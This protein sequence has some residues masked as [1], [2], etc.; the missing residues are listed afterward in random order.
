M[1][2]F[3]HVA[4]IYANLLETEESFYRTKEFNSYR[5]GLEHRH[6]RRF[7]TFHQIELNKKINKMPVLIFDGKFVLQ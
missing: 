3:T 6:G 4:G 1:S 2:I 5:I 7:I